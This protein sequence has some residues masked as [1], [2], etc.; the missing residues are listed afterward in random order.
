[1]YNVIMSRKYNHKLKTCVDA[2]VAALTYHNDH[3][4]GL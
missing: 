3:L 4:Y 1:M 2:V